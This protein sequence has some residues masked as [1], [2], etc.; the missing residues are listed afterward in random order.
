MSVYHMCGWY[1]WKQE[2]VKLGMG[3]QI[4][5]RYHVVARN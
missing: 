5:M 3:L 1:L 4:V 2:G